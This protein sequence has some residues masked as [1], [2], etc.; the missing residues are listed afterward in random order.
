MKQIVR[1]IRQTTRDDTLLDAD[2][3][4]KGHLDLLVITNSHW[5]HISGF[6]DAGA[7]SSPM[8]WQESYGELQTS[9]GMR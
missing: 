5:D 8:K 2:G 4:P 7:E 9:N 6:I 1:D 3:E